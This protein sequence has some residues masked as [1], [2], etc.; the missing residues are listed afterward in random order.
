MSYGIT[1]SGFVAKRLADIKSEIETSLRSLLGAGIN[2]DPESTLGQLVGIFAVSLAEAWELGEDIYNSAY[3][4]TAEGVPLDNAA[5]ITNTLRLG[6]TKSSVEVRIT[7][8]ATTAIPA[9][10]AFI[11][12]VL[13][14]ATARFVNTETGAI[15]A[16]G[17]DEVQDIDFSAVPASGDFKLRYNGSE[18]TA[19]IAWNATATDVQNAL[20]ALTSLSAVTV[21]GDF[22]LGFTVTFAGADGEQDHPI[23]EAVDN[24]LNGGITIAI[25]ETTRGWLPYV[26]I[27]FQAETAGVVQAPAGSLT[28]IETPVTGIDAAENLL[29]ADVGS[30]VETDSELKDRRTLQLQRAGTATIEGIRNNILQVVDVVQALVFENDTDVTDGFG[31]PPH[32]FES[33]VDGGLDAAVAAAIFEA[34]GAGIKAYG[35]TIVA[36][37]DSMSISHD[38]GFSRPTEIDI[39]MIINITPRTDATEGDL[40]PVDGDAQVEAA[41]LAYAEDFIM[42]QDVVVNLFYTPVNSIAGVIGVEILVGLSDPPT[43]SNNLPISPNEIA[44][45]DSTRITVNS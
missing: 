25:V 15:G 38:I 12:S 13:G 1:E 39:W 18:T 21:A 42:G 43:L 24:T 29:D 34:K 31:R 20:N 22:T 36:V 23:L 17:I 27:D 8:T 44:K 32:S 14:D 41:V 40:Y 2:L 7:G 9:I 30:A 26:D 6:A 45:F 5:S 37:T 3:P 11:L 35:T 16:T 19:V 28:V 4:D 10:G 33:I